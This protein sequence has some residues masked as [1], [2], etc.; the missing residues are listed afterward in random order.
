MTFELNE[1]FFSDDMDVMLFLKT[2]F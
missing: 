1:G 2:Q